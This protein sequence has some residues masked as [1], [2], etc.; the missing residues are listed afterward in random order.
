MKKAYLWTHFLAQH[1]W[2]QLCP[3]VHRTAL[4]LE[5]ER[6]CHLHSL[7]SWC[8]SQIFSVSSFRHLFPGEKISYLPIFPRES[9]KHIPPS[10]LIFCSEQSR[11]PMLLCC[12]LQ[13]KL[14]TQ[15]VRAKICKPAEIL[16]RWFSVNEVAKKGKEKM[17]GK[18]SN[19]K[20]VERFRQFKACFLES[21]LKY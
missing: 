7:L 18:S 16:V 14:V 8:S 15:K 6:R 21:R 20:L 4:S 3:F 12:P 11:I 5:C 2:R 13:Q 17:R 1:R 19:G 9:L 10:F